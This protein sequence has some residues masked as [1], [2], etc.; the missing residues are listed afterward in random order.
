MNYELKDK[1]K[2][3]KDFLDELES[4]SWQEIEYLQAQISNIEV[5]DNNAKIIQLL[6]NLLTSYYVFVGRLEN[7]DNN[8]TQTEIDS[9]ID[10]DVVNVDLDASVDVDNTKPELTSNDTPVDTRINDEFFE[11]FEYFI[12]FDEPTGEPLTDDDIYNI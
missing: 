9:T 12:D 7:L 10:T 6:K 11:P 8:T 5:T 3:T 1:I 4:K 2:V